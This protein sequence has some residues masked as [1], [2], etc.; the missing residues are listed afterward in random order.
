MTIEQSALAQLARDQWMKLIPPPIEPAPGMCVIR[1]EDPQTRTNLL[2]PKQHRQ[3]EGQLS[4]EAR[5]LAVNPRKIPNKA[6]DPIGPEDYGCV[7]GNR[8]LTGRTAGTFYKVDPNDDVVYEV[9]AW[10][11]INAVLEELPE[12]QEM[13]VGELDLGGNEGPTLTRVEG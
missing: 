5:V 9:T 12:I 3:S 4:C 11:T 1:R 10:N 2:L 6:G 13:E 7:V 8:V